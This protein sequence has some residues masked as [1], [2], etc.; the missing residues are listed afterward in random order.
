MYAKEQ[1]HGVSPRQRDRHLEAR[2][3]VWAWLMALAVLC[4]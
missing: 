3:V 1:M 2:E 4:R